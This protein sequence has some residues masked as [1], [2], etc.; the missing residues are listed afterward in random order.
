MYLLMR[1]RNGE[2]VRAVVRRS[3]L[4]L[5]LLSRYGSAMNP[6]PAV[7]AGQPCR[8]HSSLFVAFCEL[9]TS[10]FRNRVGLRENTLTREADALGRLYQSRKPQNGSDSNQEESET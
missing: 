1:H 7:I 5:A 9:G 4:D 6:I 3:K 2:Y 8:K 10:Y